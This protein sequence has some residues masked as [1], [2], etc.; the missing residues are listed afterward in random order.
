MR[1]VLTL[2]LLALATFAKAQPPLTFSCLDL[3]PGPA[4]SHVTSLFNYGDRMIFNNV[5]DEYGEEPWITDGTVGGTYL[6]KD[7]IPGPD[8]SNAEHFTI[9]DGK[10]FF[11]VYSQLWVSDG[12]VTGTRLVTDF[13]KYVDYS[14]PGSLIAINHLLLFTV[15]DSTHGY[16]L[17][18]SDGTEEGTHLLKDLN[19]GPASSEINF[20]TL[21]HNKIYFAN[22]SSPN[23]FGL[24]A[25]DGTEAGTKAILQSPVADSAHM[26]IDLWEASNKLFFGAYDTVHGNELWVSDGTQDGTH[27]LKDINPGIA[28]GYFGAAVV[29][30]NNTEA[31]FIDNDGTGRGLWVTDGTK[32]GTKHIQQVFADL[33]QEVTYKDK[34]WFPGTTL[35]SGSRTLWYSDGT[36]NGTGSLK[37]DSD[38]YNT[39]LLA[40]YKGNLYFSASPYSHLY[41]SDG[42]KEGTISIG[43]NIRFDDLSD[44]GI[45]HQFAGSLWV[46]GWTDSTGLELWRITDTTAIP[47]QPFA[48][49]PNPNHGSF[50]ISTT[51]SNFTGRIHICDVA[52]REVYYNNHVSGSIINVTIPG[53]AAGV[54]FLTRQDISDP[55]T[56]RTISSY[57]IVVW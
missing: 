56:S 35:D 1:S 27:F 55:K 15:K 52:G 7:I 31:L 30:V 54:Y 18:V 16:E 12:T 45:Y 14:Y 48:I 47:P 26:L 41:K 32:E 17:W 43:D 49:Y 46:S 20:P 34:I 23:Q 50:T 10:L 38:E 39:R 53:A 24:W 8:G 44:R 19:P 36:I 33:F 2:L 9:V 40:A 13:N 21:F 29:S 5:T 37:N 57:K 22:T 25:T 28:N 6:L 11:V 51:D 4:S 42:T 3:N